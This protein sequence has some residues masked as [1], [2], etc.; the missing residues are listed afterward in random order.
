MQSATKLE[1]IGST[2]VVS[3]ERKE[4]CT[5]EMSCSWTESRAKKDVE[6]TLKY[7]PMMWELKKRYG[8]RVEQY[9]VIIDVLG[10]CSKPPREV[11]EEATRSESTGPT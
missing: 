11:G 4:V 6:R 8:Y 3:H 9:S 7:G 10:G 5:I 2:R 1:Q